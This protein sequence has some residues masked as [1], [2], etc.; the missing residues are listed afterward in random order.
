MKWNSIEDIDDMTE[1]ELFRLVDSYGNNNGL[2]DINE[3]QVFLRRL[4][5]N[6]TKD[7][8]KEIFYHVKYSGEINKKQQE[9]DDSIEINEEEFKECFKYII[10]AYANKSLDLLGLGSK[11][12]RRYMIFF[13]L[14]LF[15][16]LSF[17]LVGIKAFATGGVFNTIINSSI[18]AGNKIR[19]S[20]ILH[21]SEW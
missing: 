15:L 20:I 12:L 1:E 17:L 3:F 4:N 11:R 13:A 2:L 16:I 14:V 8:V 6:L 7:K 19:K 18:P 21:L 9:I 5:I 10:A